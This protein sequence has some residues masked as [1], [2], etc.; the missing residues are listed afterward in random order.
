MPL[1][2]VEGDYML[3]KDIASCERPYEKA[4]EFGV[5]SLS[6][7]EL[8]ATIIRTGYGDGSSIDLSNIILNCHYLYKGLLSLNY[9]E[10]EDLISIKGI[11]NTKATQILAIAELSRR[12]VKQKLKNEIYFMNAE[13][14][15]SYYNEKCKYLK[16]ERLYLMLF[17]TANMLIK[18]ILLS[19]GTVNQ[20]LISTRE[21]FVQ[22]LKYEAVNMILVHN[23]PSGNVEPSKS[24]I[25]VTYRVYEAG[26]LLGIE[27]FDHIIIGYD[28]Y[29][30]MH[31]RGII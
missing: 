26:K 3:I 1:G 25:N 7:A 28:K 14:I 29:F 6:D 9:L 12:M 23:H 30:S 10:R 11:G 31:E 21:I 18:E 5:D 20:S 15:V 4:L 8:L 17:N 27:L 19:E 2:E 16:K 22:A 13:S 24:D